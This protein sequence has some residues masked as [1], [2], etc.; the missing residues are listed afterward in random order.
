MKSHSVTT[1]TAT[2]STDDSSLSVVTASPTVISPSM[3]DFHQ[4]VCSRIDTPSFNTQPST[5]NTVTST[6]DTQI[7]AKD[8][9]E[10]GD[11][12]SPK[13]CT[14]SALWETNHFFYFFFLFLYKEKIHAGTDLLLNISLAGSLS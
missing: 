10:S 6:P 9:E 12:Q 3:K 13:V 5:G 1:A 2:L 11:V 8:T 4:S 14:F 7:L